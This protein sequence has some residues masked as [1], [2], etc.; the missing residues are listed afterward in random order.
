M[1]G[2]FV[3]GA[4][5]W[6]PDPHHVT[7][8]RLH[9]EYDGLVAFGA[10]EVRELAAQYR[11]G[12][13]DQKLTAAVRKAG[14]PDRVFQVERIW[15]LG[16]FR[17]LDAENLGSWKRP[18]DPGGDIAYNVGRTRRGEFPA[19]SGSGLAGQKLFYCRRHC[20]IG[21]K[22]EIGLAPGRIGAFGTK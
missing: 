16:T 13:Y 8:S 2:S 11:H 17:Y 15:V 7:L 4:T 21:F 12:L 19:E 10:A 22:V 20:S 18:G 14:R 1:A 3:D 6:N 5:G 9:F